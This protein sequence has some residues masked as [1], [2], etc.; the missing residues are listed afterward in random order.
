MRKAFDY[1]QWSLALSLKERIPNL[2]LSL[3]QA[4]IDSALA[5]RRMS[6][7]R[8]DQKEIFIRRLNMDDISENDFFYL[9]G[10]SPQVLHQRLGRNHS[11]L[12][13]FERALVNHRSGEAEDFAGYLKNKKAK[14]ASGLL[15]IAVPIITM[16]V[17][18]LRNRM[19]FFIEQKRDLF[20]NSEQLRKL[21][22]EILLPKLLGILTR[23]LVL[24]LN[25]ARLRGQLVG[26]TPEERFD[27]YTKRIQQSE[28]TFSIFQEYPVLARLLIETTI[29]QIDVICEFLERLYTDIDEVVRH[30][31]AGKEVGAIERLIS[32]GDTHCSGRNVLI[33]EFTSGFRVVYK[34]K[35]LTIDLHFQQFL[36]WLNRI[37]ATPAF[38]TLGILAKDNY[39]WVEYIEHQPCT[40]P[41]ELERF[42]MRQGAYLALL[43]A[44]RAPDFHQDNLIA[45]GEHPMLIDLESLFQ[46][47][48]QMSLLKSDMVVGEALARSVLFVGL[49][50]K[51]VLGSIEQEGLDISGL[52][53][54][55]GQIT[56][57]PVPDW[58]QVGKDTM[59]LL[60]RPIEWR[61]GNNKPNLKGQ[62]VNI[63]DY[64]EAFISGFRTMYNLLIN[65]QET[66]LS[67]E[68]ILSLFKNDRIRVI[69]RPTWIYGQ[70]IR[71][72]YHPD[73]LKDAL[74]RDRFIDFLW[75]YAELL[76]YSNEILK[77]ERDDLLQ[78]DIP[79]FTTQPNSCDLWT[80]RDVCIKD[81]FDVP[82]MSLVKR[83]ILNL[84]S[85]DLQRQLWFIRASFATLSIGEN[86]RPPAPQTDATPSRPCDA[87][88]KEL[89]LSAATEIGNQLAKLALSAE[90]ETTWIGL[91]LVH[92]NKWELR[93]SGLDLYSGLSG[94]ILFLGYLAKISNNQRFENLTWSATNAWIRRIEANRTRFRYIG[95]FCGWGG[96]IYSLVHL[97]AIFDRQDL[98]AK[99]IEIA[100]TSSDLIREDSL[101]DIIGGAA[102]YIVALRSLFQMA[103]SRTILQIMKTCGDHL[104]AHAESSDRGTAWLTIPGNPPLGGFGHGVSGIAWALSELFALTG[105]QDYLEAALHATYYERSLFSTDRQNWQDLRRTDGEPQFMTAWCHGAPGIGLSRARMLRIYE[106]EDLET[107]LSIA[108]STTLRGGFGFSHC[109]CHGDLGNLE[110][111]WEAG[112]QL[113][114]NH[115]KE[116]AIIQ[117]TRTIHSINKQGWI[118]G[119]PQRIQTPDLMVGLAGIGYGFLRLAKPDYIPSVLTLDPPCFSSAELHTT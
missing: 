111:L 107:E 74:E 3:T 9:L 18:D 50:P 56:P 89:F 83:S 53:G 82:S 27:S 43:Y 49:L 61:G 110:L 75:G 23:T 108:V 70:L 17:D 87:V 113:N 42:Y 24:E 36:D 1:V 41:E 21:A 88:G 68:G 52:G 105:R 16:A 38:R 115:L 6:R 31:N 12:L 117:A 5:E 57:F 101:F 69:L 28:V 85:L 102:G 81:Y 8:F 84:D 63:L 79:L 118:C 7:W 15:N 67:E 51:R 47:P 25:I 76:P 39:G 64:A 94:I 99:A 22:L 35:S 96:V 4:D 59:C 103:P 48:P 95:G 46:P 54:E 58:E 86:I 13:W 119:V 14:N 100:E 90:D 112:Q 29:N 93:P 66:L 60:R 2:P 30:F 32:S 19:E 26:Q 71:E 77:A 78:G 114:K 109:L 10:E 92:R 34:P 65:N 80:S 72:S 44:L 37:G 104:L 33:A 62:E 40:T 116:E 55:S 98:L 91:T 106:H 45:A 97:A 11:W 20:R 73:L